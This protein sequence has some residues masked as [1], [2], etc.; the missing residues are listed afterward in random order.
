[1]KTTTTRPHGNA[2]T[3]EEI[4]MSELQ[5]VMDAAQ[6]LRKH[7]LISKDSLGEIRQ[8]VHTDCNTHMERHSFTPEV[9]VALDGIWQQTRPL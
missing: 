2:V 1:M 9:V 6:L 4:G 7:G 3:I 8:T 5:A